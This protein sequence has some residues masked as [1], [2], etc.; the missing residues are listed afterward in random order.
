MIHV[1]AK[2]KIPLYVRDW[3]AFVPDERRNLSGHAD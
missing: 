2:D 1:T 3:G